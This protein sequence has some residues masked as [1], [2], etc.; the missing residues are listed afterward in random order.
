MFAGAPSELAELIAGKAALQK[1][2]SNICVK[3]IP[4][5]VERYNKPR[6]EGE[7]TAR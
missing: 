6:R 3:L 1:A 2:A 7:R 4:E 5:A